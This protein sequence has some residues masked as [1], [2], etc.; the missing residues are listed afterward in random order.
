MISRRTDAAQ[1][2]SIRAEQ[3]RLTAAAAENKASQAAAAARR[4]PAFADAPTIRRWL[5]PQ[6]LRAQFVL[7]EIFQPALALRPERV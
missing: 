2:Q 3:A 1:A 7:T 4:G 5:K 6:T